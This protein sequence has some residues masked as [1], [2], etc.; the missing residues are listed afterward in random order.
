[1]APFYLG[2]STPWMLLATGPLRFCVLSTGRLS[3]DGQGA[4][5]RSSATP[6]KIPARI[7]STRSNS[8]ALPEMPGPVL[9][10]PLISVAPFP[11]ASADVLH[12]SHDRT[13]RVLNPIPSPGDA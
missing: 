4:F 5:G 10:P 1:M 2:C 13:G 12:L 8:T 11:V 3:R 6:L 7:L 9:P